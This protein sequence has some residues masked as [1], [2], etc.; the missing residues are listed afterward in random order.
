MDVNSVR[1]SEERIRRAYWAARK[2]IL[3]STEFE[4]LPHT[5]L[6]VDSLWEQLEKA[7]DAERPKTIQ[8]SVNI[9]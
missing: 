5:Q 8:T 4:N 1:W 6:I 9:G 3:A 7:L 2:K